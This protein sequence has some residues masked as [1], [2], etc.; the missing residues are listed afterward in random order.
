[1][2]GQDA[3]L[4]VSYL[5]GKKIKDHRSS[6]ADLFEDA[7]WFAKVRFIQKNSTLFEVLF[8]VMFL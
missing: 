2:V 5:W 8:Q 3:L 1:M 6:L 4:C 7:S